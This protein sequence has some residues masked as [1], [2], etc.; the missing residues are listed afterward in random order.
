MNNLSRY[1]TRIVRGNSLSWFFLLAVVI[2]LIFAYIFFIGSTLEKPQ[3]KLDN[4]VTPNI[5][6]APP[7]EIAEG[8]PK[9]LPLNSKISIT[10][11]YEATYPNSSAEHAT[12]EF[13]SSKSAEVNYNFYLKWAK[14][15]GWDVINSSDNGGFVSFLYFRKVSEQINITIRASA[16]TATS[17]DITISYVDLNK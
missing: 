15:N 5:T 6:E 9:D 10:Q 12:V 1:Y 2:I 11:S 17:S 3:S 8:F 4:I 16:K 14:N 7:Q 13:I